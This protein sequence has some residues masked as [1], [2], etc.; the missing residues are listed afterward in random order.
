MHNK[1][2]LSTMLEFI[3]TKM[4]IKCEQII[5][6]SQLR[7]DFCQEFKM[8][9]NKHGRTRPTRVIGYQY[10]LTASETDAN[11]MIEFF[12]FPIISKY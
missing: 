12:P 11:T 4:K 5:T 10:P 1:K 7:M 6:T 8:P 9:Q 3:K 2:E